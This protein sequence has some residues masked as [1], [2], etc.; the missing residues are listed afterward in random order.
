M[1]VLSSGVDLLLPKVYIAE[2]FGIIQQQI[3]YGLRA[4]DTW[5]QVLHNNAK[6]RACGLKESTFTICR[7]AS[8]TF[9]ESTLFD[10]SNSS[11]ASAMACALCF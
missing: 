6:V 7:F 1:L 2:R 5:T 9:R 11:I 3:G 4:E 8:D 10:L